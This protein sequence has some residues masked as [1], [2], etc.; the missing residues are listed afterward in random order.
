[1]PDDCLKKHKKDEIRYIDLHTI[2]SLHLPCEFHVSRG[3]EGRR[4]ALLAES[5]GTPQEA[6]WA[7]VF[8]KRT[9]ID[10]GHQTCSFV[11]GVVM[12]TVTVA[13]ITAVVEV[14]MV[15]CSRG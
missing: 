6:W 13:V 11:A 12:V 1:M 2:V 8:E 5:A 3:C 4:I 9:N 7:T 14:V 10:G 15:V